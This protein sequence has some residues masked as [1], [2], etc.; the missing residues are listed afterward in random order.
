MAYRSRSITFPAPTKTQSTDNTD[1]SLSSTPSEAIVPGVD[2]CNHSTNANSR[3]S[4]WNPALL[5]V[6]PSKLA[7]ILLAKPERDKRNLHVAI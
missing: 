7:L 3:W 1:S 2:L 6:C 5:K 4:V